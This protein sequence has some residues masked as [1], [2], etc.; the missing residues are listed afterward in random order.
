[1]VVTMDKLLF[2]CDIP[3]KVDVDVWSELLRRYISPG[4]SSAHDTRIHK[5]VRNRYI[6]CH[7]NR[8]LKF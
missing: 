1:M 6:G 4:S 3:L 7:G 2:S 5:N 8:L